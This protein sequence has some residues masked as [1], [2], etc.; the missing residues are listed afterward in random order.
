MHKITLA[1]ALVVALAFVACKKD[2]SNPVT[3]VVPIADSYFPV[4]VGNVWVYDEY[5]L[6]SLGYSI[7]SSWAPV[8][9][10]I[11]NTFTFL[12]RP[13][14]AMIHFRADTLTG[15]DT[16]SVGI[17]GTYATLI[18]TGTAGPQW[19]VSQH[20]GNTSTTK[21][22]TTKIPISQTIDYQGLPIPINT[23]LT[24]IESY[25]GPLTFTIPAGTFTGRWYRDTTYGSFNV[26]IAQ[27]QLN[28]AVY[29][30]YVQNVGPT[31]TWNF[32]VFS[33]SFSGTAFGQ[34]TGT[35][36]ELRSY[37]VKK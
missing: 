24:I 10:S 2:T 1:F 14:F 16:Q 3:P 9:D 21:F 11:I 28:G 25:I 34:A 32:Q 17:D 26:I 36:R 5:T 15:I 30:T 12:G 8:K 35:Y 22:D 33:A 18:D 6:D 20:L 19:A 29:T 37:A 31:T 23:T 13:A 7:I 4:A 27:A